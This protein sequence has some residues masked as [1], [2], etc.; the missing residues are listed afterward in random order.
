MTPLY[1]SRAFTEAKS[2]DLRITYYTPLSRSFPLDVR[3]EMYIYETSER[4]VAH[5][6][7]TWLFFGLPTE[8]LQDNH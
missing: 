3:D 8:V 1:Y 5:F 4:R 2:F 6:L 7:Q